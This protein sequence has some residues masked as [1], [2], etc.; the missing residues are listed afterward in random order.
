MC[1]DP[2]VTKLITT[3][4]HLTSIERMWYKKVVCG[5]LCGMWYADLR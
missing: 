1:L 4:F 5:I 2:K 3:A